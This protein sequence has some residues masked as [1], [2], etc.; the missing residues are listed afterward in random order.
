MTYGLQCR[1]RSCTVAYMATTTENT[2]SKI[3]HDGD[4]LT[5]SAK[6]E[7]GSVGRTYR[8]SVE[9]SNGDEWSFTVDQP[10]KGYWVARGWRG[11]KSLPGAGEFK[12]YREAKTA[13]DAKAQ[14]EAQANLAATDA[15]RWRERA[16]EVGVLP[17]TAAEQLGAA[18]AALAKLGTVAQAA[19]SGPISSLVRALI[20][21]Q[22]CG[23]KTPV[24]KMSCGNG[25][26][27]RVIR[28]A[29]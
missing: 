10:R 1:T 18:K 23:C 27:P 9:V 7:W 12:F 3:H 6:S 16:V 29:A 20:A 5:W 4:E 24:H 2:E 11:H 15:D 25:A 19:A 22:P 28:R 13:K 17:R 21:G 8:M 14:C 26:T